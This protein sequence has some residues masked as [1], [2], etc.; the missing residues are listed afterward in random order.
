MKPGRTC[1]ERREWPGLRG[2]RTRAGLSLVQASEGLCSPSTLW[3]W[4]VGEY[5]PPEFAVRK[6]ADLYG[7]SV[8]SLK[9]AKP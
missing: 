7:V 5:R 2:A 3:G 1:E 4:E 9:R 6:L 8:R